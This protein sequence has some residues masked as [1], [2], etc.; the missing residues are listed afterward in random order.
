M[1]ILVTGGSGLLGRSIITGLKFDDHDVLH[2]SSKELD[3]LDLTKTHLFFKENEPD[4]VIHC[5]ARVGGIA[6]NISNPYSFLS[7][8]LRIDL[9]TI[10]AARFQKTKNF[11]YMGS[12]CM[13]PKNSNLPLNEEDL[14]TGPL[15]ET[16][17]SYALAK[18]SGAQL[19]ENVARETGL[20]WRTLILSNLYGPNDHFD[21][22]RSHLV[23]AVINKVFDAKLNND[24]TIEMWGT[25][26][27]R[28]EFT[29][30]QDVAD[31]IVSHIDELSEFPHYM[32]LGAG[33]DYSVK[34]YY[35][36]VLSAFGFDCTIKPRVD[37]PSGMMRKLMNVKKAEAFG[38]N[39]STKIEDG[40][41]KTLEFYL[42]SKG[43]D[44]D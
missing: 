24:K 9:N 18:L 41:R 28:R 5:A 43:V 15:E 36:F 29:F 8:N 42:E 26:L 23:A 39:P 21:S 30:V 1:R 27:A 14:L 34:E 20:S 31:F 19:V 37:L 40:L 22:E 25:G 4:A 32:N 35:D 7:E 6:A 13:Y 44:F 38:W 33:E 12:S 10:Q 3:L 2:P 17:K 11:L 16:N